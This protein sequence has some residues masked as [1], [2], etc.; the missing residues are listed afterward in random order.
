[1]YGI[2]TYI[3]H[4]HQL[5]VAKYTKRGWYGIY[6]LIGSRMGTDVYERGGVNIR[7]SYS[8]PFPPFVTPTRTGSQNDNRAT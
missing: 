2:F 8:R 4:K 5:N 1:M 6:N 7:K 3:Q